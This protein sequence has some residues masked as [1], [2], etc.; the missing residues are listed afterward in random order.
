[1]SHLGPPP[2]LLNS[3]TI[4]SLGATLALLF[5]ALTL[6]KSLLPTRIYNDKIQRWTFV[7]LAFDALTHFI[8]EGSFLYQSFPPLT[9]SV[10]TSKGP[11]ALLWQEYARADTRWG[12]SDPTVVSIEIITVLMCGPLCVVLM[13]MMRKQNEAWRYWIVVL[14]TAEIYG[15]MMTFFPEW[16]TG[17]SAL[18]TTHWLYTY[19]YLLFFNGLWVVIPLY[20]MYDS[21][22]HIV[23][24]LRTSNAVDKKRQ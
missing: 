15:G 23:G 8:L 14:S 19:V 24:A 18:N 17:S 20:L 2:T 9:S 5:A 1:M 6:A 11:F 10:N 4:F 7:W 13:D 16:I 3:T 21:Y 22:I 12:T